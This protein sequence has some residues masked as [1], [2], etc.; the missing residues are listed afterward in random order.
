[1]SKKEKLTK[2]IKNSA[3]ILMPLIFSSLD[4]IEAISSAMELRAFG[5]NKKRTWYNGRP[6]KLGD[7]I[8]ILVVSIKLSLVTLVSGFIVPCSN[9][10]FIPVNNSSF[11]N[12]SNLIFNLFDTSNTS[13]NVN[14]FI[15]N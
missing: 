5:S 1:M 8:T 15:T 4:R 10:I 14:I 6:F 3:S 9:S 13:F 11:V 2:R 12:L 7:Y